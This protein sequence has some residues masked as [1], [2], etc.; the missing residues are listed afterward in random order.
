MAK[1]I[2]I[3]SIDG[4]G[5][6]GIIPGTILHYIETEI[7]KRPGQETTKLADHFDLIA[8]TS[9]GGIL[10][11]IYL[12]PDEK[13]L[14]KYTTEAALNLYLQNGAEIFSRSFWQKLRT[15]NGVAGAKYSADQIAKKLDEYFGDHWIS[16]LRRPCIITSYDIT[17]RKTV[18]FN[19][20]NGVDNP[21]RN[22]KVKDVTRATSAAPTYFKPAHITSKIGAIST[23]VDGGVFANN[24]AL[25]AYSEARSLDFDQL[26]ETPGT[27]AFPSAKD[28][29][30]LSIGTGTVKESY[31]YDKAK[32]WGAIGWIKPVIDVMMS[33]NS[34]TVD[35]QLSQIFDA[36]NN[37]DYYHRIQ[38]GLGE[39]NSQMDDVSAQNLTALHQAGLEYI[40]SNQQALNKIVDQILP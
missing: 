37:S 24:P 14:S 5:I 28:M 31:H 1:K 18:F 9:T 35:Y 32:K 3:L 7:Q 23:L 2:K 6:R 21:V 22:Y 26:L 27:K 8:G 4:G 25:C 36:T 29:M 11:C 19:K 13:G 16:E 12:I 40:S 34:E 20:L 10:T 15:L 17:N 39:A 30:L 33:G 38:P